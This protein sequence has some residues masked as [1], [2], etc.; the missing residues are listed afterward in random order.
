MC[1]E[2]ESERYNDGEAFKVTCRTDAGVMVT[3]IA[4][5]YFG[6]CKKEVKTQISYAANLMGGVEEE[7]AGG[8]LVF[9][10]WSL[11][12]ELQVNSRRYNGRTFEDVV[13]E[14][15]GW[16][17]VK[18]EGYGVD[19]K[20]P[21]LIYIPEDARADLREQDIRWIRGGKTLSIPLL[22]GKVYIAPSG[23]KVHMEKHP[24]APLGES[25][26]RGPREPSATSPTRSAAAA[27]ARSASRWSTT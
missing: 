19:K 27:R 26:A 13:R 23:Y 7:H 21:D 14:Y 1:W 3:I 4:D 8:A 18:P 16:I 25:S 17:D 24:C 22:P 2:D 9:P 12:E 11:G 6:Y 10:S 20:Y 5:N 15:G